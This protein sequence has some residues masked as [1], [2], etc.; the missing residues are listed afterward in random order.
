[1][2]VWW[3]GS[4]DLLKREISE[5]L[6]KEKASSGFAS[7]TGRTGPG[8]IRLNP[9]KIQARTAEALNFAI[10]M[11]TPFE[12]FDEAMREQAIREGDMPGPG[13]YHNE[14][15]T[16]SLKMNYKPTKLQFFGSS[17]LRFQD[18][19]SQIQL[20]PGEYTISENKKVSYWLIET[21]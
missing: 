15:T 4:Y 5:P 18:D 19:G 21:E 1:M 14:R 16:S 7:T 11:D 17:S 13:Y 12:G 9:T 8:G 20:G 10:G 6:Y 3:I 2:I